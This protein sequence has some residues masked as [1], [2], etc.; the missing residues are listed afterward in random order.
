MNIELFRECCLALPEVTED[1]PFDDTVVT[2]RL[3]GK[4]FAC[5]GVDHPDEAVLKCDPEK[6]ETLRMRYG[7]VSGAFHW[8]KKYWN[9]IAFQ[10]DVDDRLFCQLIV[11]A[12]E[13]V[14]LKLPKR[15]RVSVA[16][17]QWTEALIRMA[18]G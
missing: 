16:R 1:M 4:I 18:A 5:V 3:K 13:E 11:H 8:N 9:Q 6:A 7:A 2:F 14:N 12:Y 17:E 15:E 10:R